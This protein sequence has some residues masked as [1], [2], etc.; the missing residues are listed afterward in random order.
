MPFFNT[1]SSRLHY[2]EY[3]NGQ[4]VLLAFH[5][6][7]MRGTQF[8]VLEDAFGSRYRIISF[9]LF[10]HGQT[11]LNNNSVHHIRKGLNAKEFA[12]HIGQFIDSEFSQTEKVA[13]LSY[14]LGT[15]MAF[16]LIDNLPHRISAA[17]LIAPDG[18]EPNKLLRLGG[19]NFVV[20]RIFHQLVYSPKVIA[21]CLSLLLKLNYVDEALHRI[22]KAEFGTTETRLTCYN[23]IT[24]YA[25]LKFSRKRIAQAINTYNIDCH[26]Y[27]GKKDKLF[28]S[29]IGE[30]FSTLLAVPNIHVF[31]DGHEL[32][33]A[34]MNDYL[35]KQLTKIQ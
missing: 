29:K 23:T 2:H 8:K 1:G 28:P 14:S 24:Y 35:A 5:G 11:C 13:L 3:G 15:R 4:E 30:R 19:D 18:I 9:D 20:N 7:G 25:K 27:F 31:D 21:F 26:F 17:Y 34:A 16:C 12:S 6:F 10:F 32:V 22:L 33:N